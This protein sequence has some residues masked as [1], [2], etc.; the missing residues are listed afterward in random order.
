MYS[1]LND[2]NAKAAKMSVVCISLY[3]LLFNF[4]EKLHFVLILVILIQDIM[5]ELY[6]KNVWN[7][8]K[9]VNV[10]STACFSKVTKVSA[11]F[12]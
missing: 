2:T 6:R 8:A 1:M 3:Q 12:F 10:I 9:T 7:D 11:L 5:I 4:L